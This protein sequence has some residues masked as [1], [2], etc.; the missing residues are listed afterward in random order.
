[1][2]SESRKDAMSMQDF[3]ERVTKLEKRLCADQIVS[4]DIKEMASSIRVLAEW[5]SEMQ[6]AIF[7]L[8]EITEALAK[9]PAGINV[10]YGK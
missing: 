6:P 1:M 2:S 5:M 10:T 9:R 4:D 8:Q 3:I 7:Q